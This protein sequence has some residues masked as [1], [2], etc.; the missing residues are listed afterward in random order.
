MVKAILF[1]ADQVPQDTP[2]LYTQEH[3][4][5]WK[6]PDAYEVFFGDAADMDKKLLI[7]YSILEHLDSLNVRASL[8]SVEWVDSPYYRLEP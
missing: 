1:L 6:V 5:G 3:G 4:F 7:Y 8:I 2:L